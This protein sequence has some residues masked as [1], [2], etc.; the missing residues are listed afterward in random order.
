MAEL[1]DTKTNSS[2]TYD[3]GLWLRQ[4]PRHFVAEYSEMGLDPFEN[5]PSSPIFSHFP[6]S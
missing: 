3:E 2:A 4:S 1:D 6:E 5:V